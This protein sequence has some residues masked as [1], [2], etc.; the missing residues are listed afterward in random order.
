MAVGQRQW[1]GLQ[2]RCMRLRKYEGQFANAIRCLGISTQKIIS[3]FVFT[4]HYCIS[5]GT[6]AFLLPLHFIS[7]VCV[8][9][10]LLC[11]VCYVVVFAHI[12]SVYKANKHT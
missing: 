9:M 6:R 12:S 3:L 10:L 11:Y 4:L 2:L 7:C 5:F 8:C 1:K